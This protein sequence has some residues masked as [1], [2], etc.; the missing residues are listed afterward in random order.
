MKSPSAVFPAAAAALL[1]VAQLSHAAPAP[2]PSPAASPT[3]SA[4]PSALFVLPDPVAVV[5]GKPISKLELENALNT[6]LKSAGKTADELPPD[7]RAIGYRSLLN[8]LVIEHLVTSRSAAIKI[9]DKAVDETLTKLKSEFPSE[10]E[11]NDE[12]K[13]NGQTLDSIK[14]RIRISLQ[15]QKWMDQQIA[16]KTDVTDAEAKAFYDQN[17]DKF[18]VPETV[19][20]S[21]I[22]IATPE[23]ATPEVLAAKEK[24]AKATYERVKKG[25]P[26]EKVAGEVSEDPGSKANGGDL[27]YFSKDRM[28]KEFADAAWKLKIGE[29]SEP[30]KSQFGFHIIKVTDKKPAHT[31]SFDEGKGKIVTF[32][33]QQKKQ[34]AI[35]ST[36]I[37]LQ[38]N[39]DVKINLPGP[40][41]A[42]DADAEPTG[43]ETDA[44]DAPETAPAAS[45]GK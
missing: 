25:E 40:T 6:A 32:L 22:L 28:V 42:P 12:L 27:D 3:A 31:V 18:E 13:K 29:I 10:A 8:D 36:L 33:S 37:D 45:P 41:E 7:Q 5:E 9:D 21:H 23:D 26:F 30:V 24:L 15:Q 44:D 17:P 39:A 19:K 1:A 35:K 43:P 34:T 2:S 4:S 38:K 16:G 11:M 20:A 14:G